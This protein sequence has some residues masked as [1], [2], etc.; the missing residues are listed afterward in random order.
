MPRKLDWS[1]ASKKLLGREENS[2]EGVRKPKVLG[3]KWGREW[4]HAQKREG[5]KAKVSHF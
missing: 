2:G 5:S 1:M 3:V 4:G